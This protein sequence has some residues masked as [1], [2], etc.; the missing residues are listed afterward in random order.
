MHQ[1]DDLFP[2]HILHG[3][4]AKVILRARIGLLLSQ[5]RLYQGRARRSGP[6]VFS[7]GIYLLPLEGFF[8]FME[9]SGRGS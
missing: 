6:Q 5:L 9:P 3:E 1:E 4:A 7:L 2:F 8:S